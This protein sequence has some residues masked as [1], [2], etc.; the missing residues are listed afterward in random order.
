ME[1]GVTHL[2]VKVALIG[3]SEALAHLTLIGCDELPRSP[4]FLIVHGAALVA[5][6]A[7]G[8]VATFALVILDFV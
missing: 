2:R 7:A 3:M 1:F 8:I 4:T 5:Q 6:W